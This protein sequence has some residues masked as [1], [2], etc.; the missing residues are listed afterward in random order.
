MRQSALFADLTGAQKVERLGA[1]YEPAEWSSSLG[2]RA[3]TCDRHACEPSAG[4]PCR[5]EKVRGDANLRCVHP[6]HLRA[7]RN[8]I[9][10]PPSYRLLPQDYLSLD[11]R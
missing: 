4:P 7:D 6:W 11:V 2:C 3:L 5:A 9:Y 8:I 10:A 1:D